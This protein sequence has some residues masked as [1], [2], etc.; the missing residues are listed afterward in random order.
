MGLLS[1]WAIFSLT[2]HAIVEYAAFKEGFPAF[3]DYY[4]L[5]DDVVI[6]DT[7]VADRY[8]KLM[9]EIG[10]EISMPKSFVSL[11]KD[12][13]HISEFAKRI[14]INGVDLSP[15]PTKLLSEAMEDIFMFPSFIKKLRDLDR[16][17]TPRQETRICSSLY[18]YIP[19]AITLIMTAPKDV[20]GVE[21]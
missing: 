13:N 8:L 21:P 2:H 7:K 16:G 12:Q 19:K 10:V 1:S 15:I 3:R 4:M 11:A 6:L 18:G 20:T 17:L 9:K 14:M 5:G